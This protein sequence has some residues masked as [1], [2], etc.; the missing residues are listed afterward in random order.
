AQAHHLTRGL[1]LRLNEMT[2]SAGA[3]VYPAYYFLHL[4]VPPS[5]LLRSFRA[6]DPVQIAVDVARYGVLM[7]DS[8]YLVS[9]PR[10]V[11]ADVPSSEWA[12]RGL[13]MMR[14]SSTFV[15]EGRVGDPQL[16]PPSQN[17]LGDLTVSAERPAASVRFR[18]LRSQGRLLPELQPSLSSQEPF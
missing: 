13:P 16:A 15:L 14:S 17:A 8:R 6:W 4:T 2:D 1:K 10:E 3:P 18:E 7:L 12:A 5:R 9:R 11:A